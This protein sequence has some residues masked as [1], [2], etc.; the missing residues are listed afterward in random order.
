MHTTSYVT[1]REMLEIRVSRIR[2]WEKQIAYERRI[3]CSVPES[4]S[5]PDCF[6]QTTELEDPG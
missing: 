6:Q 1:T 2:E 4:D 3:V 5:I